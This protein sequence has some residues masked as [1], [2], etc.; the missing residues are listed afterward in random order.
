MSLKKGFLKFADFV[1]KTCDWVIFNTVADLKDYNVIKKEV[2]A[3][4][5]SH[6]IWKIFD[7]NYFEQHLLTTASVR[8][9]STFITFFSE[10]MTP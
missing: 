4:V 7:N 9:I 3:E 6:E 5:F 10:S 8:K 2:P 1:G